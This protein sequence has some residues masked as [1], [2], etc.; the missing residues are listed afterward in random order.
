MEADKHTTKRWTG[1]IAGNRAARIRG[2][3]GQENEESSSH[4]NASPNWCH[5]ANG[6]MCIARV[7]RVMEKRAVNTAQGVGTSFKGEQTV[8]S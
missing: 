8:T 3:Q 5:A 2:G 1:S 6:L 4:R 7:G